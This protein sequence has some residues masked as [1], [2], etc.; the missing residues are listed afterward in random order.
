MDEANLE[1]GGPDAPDALSILKAMQRNS[2]ILRTFSKACGLAGLRVGYVVALDGE[3]A[4][5]MSAAKT[6][7]NGN[8]A[9]QIAALA[10]LHH[11]DCW[12]ALSAGSDR[13]AVM[14][15]PF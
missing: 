2:V 15:L 8:S 14:C 12:P 7:F 9:T 6:P 11:E 10:A 4:P 1:F 5:M 3:I 13:L